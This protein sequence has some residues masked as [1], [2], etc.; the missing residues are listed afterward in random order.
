MKINKKFFAVSL[1]TLFLV[2]IAGCSADQNIQPKPYIPP[3]PVTPARPPKPKEFPIQNDFGINIVENLAG[4]YSSYD[5]ATN[6][7]KPLTLIKAKDNNELRS[8]L[9]AYSTF[10]FSINAEIKC[11]YKYSPF[12]YIVSTFYGTIKDNI[13]DAKPV[14]YYRETTMGV[15]YCQGWIKLIFSTTDSGE[16]QLLVQGHTY[17][18]WCPNIV[19]HIWCNFNIKK[20]NPLTFYS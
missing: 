17:A 18:G 16:L 20:D 15:G 3:A 12:D 7:G 6:N 1:S 8:I 13:I 19:S 2:S 4:A 14:E 5:Q 10:V 11:D 9:S